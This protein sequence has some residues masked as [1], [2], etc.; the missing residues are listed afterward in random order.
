MRSSLGEPSPCSN[1]RQQ[2]TD[3]VVAAFA[4]HKGEV[5]AGYSLQGETEL[6]DQ[7]HT[8]S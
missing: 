4:A 1:V 8:Y 2:D 3:E 7:A 5:T 6:R